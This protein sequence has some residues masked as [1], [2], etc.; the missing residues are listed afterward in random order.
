MISRSNCLTWLC[1]AFCL[2][3]SA[4]AHAAGDPAVFRH[5]RDRGEAH[6]GGAADDIQDRRHCLYSAYRDDV[7]F[8]SGRGLGHDRWAYYPF[9]LLSIDTGVIKPATQRVASVSGGLLLI[10]FDPARQPCQPD[11]AHAD[12]DRAVAAAGEDVDV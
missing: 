6:A 9:H 8:Q 3:W 11:R 10:H 12:I 4:G 5:P 2:S 1:T 7:G